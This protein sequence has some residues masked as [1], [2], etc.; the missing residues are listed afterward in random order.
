MV[1]KIAREHSA[2]LAVVVTR[3]VYEPVNS[4][5]NILIVVHL[6][7]LTFNGIDFVACIGALHLAF[8]AHLTRHPNCQG[9]LLPGI[10]ST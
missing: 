1:K 10:F 7:L 4:C 9:G 5:P 3:Q 2:G 8:Y 6:E